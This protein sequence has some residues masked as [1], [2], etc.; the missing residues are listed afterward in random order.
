MDPYG[1][2]SLYTNEVD[3]TAT[4][5]LPSLPGEGLYEVYAWWSAE[6]PNG[7]KYNR[8]S[9]ARYS[10]AF[11]QHLGTDVPYTQVSTTVF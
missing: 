5:S 3:A 10:D 6:A 4:W 2:T 1:A 11:G 8:D 9:I 7:G